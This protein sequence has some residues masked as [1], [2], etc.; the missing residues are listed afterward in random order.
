[1][2]NK[3][4][5]TVILLGVMLV[6]LSGCIGVNRNFKHVRSH[7]LSGVN[8]NFKKETEFRIGKGLITLAGLFVSFAENET[9]VDIR[10]IIH[11]L[12]RVQIG[13]YKNYGGERLDFSRDGLISLCNIMEERDM[14]Y[15]VRTI[16]DD[17][18]TGV[19]LRDNDMDEIRDMYVVHFDQRELVIVEIKGDLDDIIAIALQEANHNIDFKESVANLD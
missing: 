10:G 9:D 16:D 4:I 17:Q 2:K 8:G 3:R 6:T 11:N 7:V 14:Y 18:L 19:F 5:L 13:I 1:M 15:I 12:D